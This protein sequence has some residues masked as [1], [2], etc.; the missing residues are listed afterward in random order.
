[1]CGGS[2]PLDRVCMFPHRTS[3]LPVSTTLM[4]R[5]FLLSRGSL[6]PRLCATSSST[7]FMS[8][9]SSIARRYG[10]LRAPSRA[11]LAN[12]IECVSRSW[13]RA[14]QLCSRCRRPS[15]S[16][17]TR[18]RFCWRLQVAYKPRRLVG[19]DCDGRV[20]FVDSQLGMAERCWHVV[21]L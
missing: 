5:P 9:V 4:N 8:F 15:S 6:M 18:A 11:A 12:P 3:E 14:P 10:A 21:H 2:R 13:R 20:I 17:V 1:M 16:P 7:W 19:H